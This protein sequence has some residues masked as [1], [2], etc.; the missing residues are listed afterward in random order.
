MQKTIRHWW[1]KSKMTQ[2]V[3]EIYNV[4]R[5]DELILWKWLYYPKQS[6]DSMQSLSN[7]LWHFSQKK[8][9]YNS[10]GNTKESK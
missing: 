6:T 2:T 3:G 7:Y 9:V 8:K 1:K 4:V 5:L 10:Y